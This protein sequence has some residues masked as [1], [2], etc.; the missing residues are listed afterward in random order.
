[1]PNHSPGLLPLCVALFAGACVVSLGSWH[2]AKRVTEDAEAAYE[3]GLLEGSQSVPLPKEYFGA[4]LVD[5][6]QCGSRVVSVILMHSPDGRPGAAI[7]PWNSPH[8]V[9]MKAMRD[10]AKMKSAY[11]NI[12]IL[13]DRI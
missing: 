2:N 9:E 1:M 10:I 8:G 7:V 11:R 3:K 5:I 4:T 13:C 6:E 12:N